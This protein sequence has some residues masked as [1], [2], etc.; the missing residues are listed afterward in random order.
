M[1]YII[2]LISVMAIILFASS[3]EF[4]GKRITALARRRLDE[5]YEMLQGQVLPD[6]QAG[7]IKMGHMVLSPFGIFVVKSKKYPGWIYGQAGEK[8][9][10]QKLF[11]TKTEL[12]NPLLQNEQ[13]MAALTKLLHGLV[14]PQHIHSVVTFP[15]QSTFKTPM[16]ANV[17]Q[18]SAWIDYIRQFQQ[19]VFT[20]EQ[21]A[22][23]RERIKQSAMGKEA[24]AVH[25]QRQ[26]KHAH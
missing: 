1:L 10:T 18:G 23:I 25:V 17:V 26:E 2:I 6:V 21:L 8:F 12:K 24:E 16:P 7:T 14:D 20:P 4:K 3:P 15:L 13:R 9:W 5:R 11:G 19:P 22:Q